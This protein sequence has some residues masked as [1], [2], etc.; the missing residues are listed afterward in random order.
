MF[1]K[2]EWARVMK[3]N[4]YLR[5]LA[6]F[7]STVE[8]GSMTAA[9]VK[10]GG[11]PSAM[12]ESVKILENYYGS[13]LLERRQSGVIPTSTGLTVYEF[14]QKMVQAANDALKLN[15]ESKPAALKISMP[16]EIACNWFHDVFSR[17]NRLNGVSHMTLLCEDEL[18]DHE[19]YSRDLFVRASSS[20]LPANINILYECSSRAVFATHVKNAESMNVNRISD[21][22]KQIFL[23]KPQNKAMVTHTFDQTGSVSPR[24]KKQVNLMFKRTI[25]INDI[26]SRLA[27]ARSGIGVVCCL[28]ES[29]RED[30]DKGDMVQLAPKKLFIPISIQI[31]SPKRNPSDA[32]LS[33]TNCL[34]KWLEGVVD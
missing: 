31:A 8:A 26:Q 13:D 12:S 2:T 6:N 4:A 25:H 11:N 17:I 22:E 21:I 33:A 16:R 5:H 30:F 19:R 24:S 14:A 28:K 18:L 15:V 20:P 10:L 32:V 9:A 23:C 7:V 1:R 34:V 3:Q 29:L 27:L